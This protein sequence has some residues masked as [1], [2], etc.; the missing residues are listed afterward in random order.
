MRGAGC[1]ERKETA[2]ERLMNDTNQTVDESGGESRQA[3]SLE[4]PPTQVGRYRIEKVL[5]QGG[6][7]CVYLA[8]DEQLQR[9]VA[10]KVPHAHLVAN[11]A[12]AG[13]YLAEARM[14]ASLDHPN[15]V[16]VYDIGRTDDC[17]F[18]IVS[19][20]IEGMTLAQRIEQERFAFRE[21]AELVATVAQALH[22]GHKKGIV[23]RDVKP[24][25]ILLDAAGKPFVADFGLALKEGTVR[26]ESKFAGTPPY[27][28][29]EQARG[30]GHRVDGRSD[31]F[32]LGVVLYELL[33]GR[34][35][36]DGN[37]WIDVLE[38][39]INREARPPAKSTTPSPGSWSVS[40]SKPSPSA[41]RSGIPR[42]STW[43]KTCNT[44]WRW[45]RASKQV[46]LGS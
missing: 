45:T 23:H 33:T 27:M 15:I 18:F 17:P 13:V 40:V 2:A 46:L 6:F 41:P 36:F 14:V 39:V 28:S 10:I 3:G 24:G 19:R 30:E 20:F 31:I 37:S 43:Q 9:P 4:A 32:S 35:P 25:N 8:Q 42:H 38:Q 7:G 44:G 26:R 5:G 21:S 22:Y 1:S 16:S 11:R 29:P 34:R 12:D